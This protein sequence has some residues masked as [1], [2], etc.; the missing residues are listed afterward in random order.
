M[1]LDDVRECVAS[2]TR[3]TDS[4]DDLA[5][6]GNWI[7]LDSLQI[8]LPELLLELLLALLTIVV[9]VLAISIAVFTTA[10]PIVCGCANKSVCKISRLDD[11]ECVNKSICKISRVHA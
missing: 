11:S 2:Q 7:I 4:F 3:C 10:I 1:R 8:L 9:A 5:T 6:E